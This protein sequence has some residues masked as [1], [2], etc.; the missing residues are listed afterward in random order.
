MARTV[1]VAGV[2]CGAAGGLALL[3]TPAAAH[4]SPDE[5]EVPAGAFATVTLSVPHGCDESPTR[6][7]SI[8]I[9]E[10]IVSVTPQVHPGWDIAVEEEPLAEPIEDEGET[11]TE[12]ISTV[13]FT[14]QAGNELP[15][16]YRDAF[17]L[18]YQAPETP[19]EWLFFK[20]VQTCVEGETAWIEEYTGEGEEPEAP[21][22]AVMVTD[23]EADAHGGG[24]E[25]EASGDEMADDAASTGDDAAAT[26][27]QAAATQESGSD[28]GDS[29]TGLAVAGLVVG[30]LGLG[31][32]GLALARTRKSTAGGAQE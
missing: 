10:S 30:G 1:R 6:Q 21:A 26:E 5:T 29:S 3:A 15:V 25:D 2:L 24:T 8:Q 28:D 4:I 18:G 11:I 23:A 27:D 12:R 16:H 9:P 17:T 13:T 7:L 20:T 14:A 31:A 19:G 32:G 22:P